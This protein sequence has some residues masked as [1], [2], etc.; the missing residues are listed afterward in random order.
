MTFR[1][2][3][4]SLTLKLQVALYKNEKE[5][6]MLIIL[7]HNLKAATTKNLL[8]FESWHRLT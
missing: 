8:F 1:D 5:D 6:N 2:H 7:S 4:Y 3:L